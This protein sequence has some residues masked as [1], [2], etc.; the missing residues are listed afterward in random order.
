[1][2]NFLASLLPLLPLLPLLQIRGMREESALEGRT[3]KPLVYVRPQDNLAKVVRTLFDNK[4]S[5]APILSCDPADPSSGETTAGGLGAGGVGWAAGACGGGGLQG[6]SKPLLFGCRWSHVLYS[7]VLK[8]SS[9]IS[10][11]GCGQNMK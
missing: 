3:P 1:V 9:L 4:C 2:V 7:I 8:C 10:K 6:P 11:H 5:M